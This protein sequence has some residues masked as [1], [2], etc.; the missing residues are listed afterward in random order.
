[1]TKTIWKFALDPLND[2]MSINMP[3]GAE[4]LSAGVQSGIVHL[5]AVVDPE[6]DK[7]PRA[8][9]AVGTGHLTFDDLGRFVGTVMLFDGQLVFHIFEQA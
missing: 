5:W 3:K 4:V 7:E 9:L 8:F 2:V 6:A 1:M